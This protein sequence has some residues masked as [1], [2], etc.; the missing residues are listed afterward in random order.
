MTAVGLLAVAMVAF[1][2]GCTPGSR[3]VETPT[4][5]PSPTSTSTPEPTK[6]PLS[7]DLR[8]CVTIGKD[9]GP[10]QA[11]DEAGADPYRENRVGIEARF[12][13]KSSVTGEVRDYSLEDLLRENPTVQPQDIACKGHRPYLSATATV[14]SGKN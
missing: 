5:L 12:E 11:L 3:A 4:P 14:T 2:S 8:T 13:I 9:R 7:S 10:L 6:V 1:G